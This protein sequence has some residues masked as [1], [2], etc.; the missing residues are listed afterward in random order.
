MTIGPR[1]RTPLGGRMKRGFGGGFTLTGFTFSGFATSGLAAFA[2]FSFLG[3]S[4]LA[5]FSFFVGIA[6]ASTAFV[7][8][9]IADTSGGSGGGA[10]RTGASGAGGATGGVIGALIGAGIP[11]Y[12]AKVYDAE[13]RGGGILIGVE[14]K[15]DEE[16]DHL[17]KLL[18]DIG[19]EHVRTE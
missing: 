4:A 16:V 12:R 2:A 8:T 11:E 15:S 10:S 13:L 6:G 17:E 1:N 18:E 5:F 9:G 7:A 19:G 3:F 14:A